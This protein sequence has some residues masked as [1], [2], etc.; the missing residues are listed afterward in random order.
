MSGYLQGIARVDLPRLYAT[1]QEPTVIEHL[2][3][4]L[5]RGVSAEVS[6]ETIR[7]DIASVAANISRSTVSSLLEVLQRLFVLESV[8]AWTPKLR[9]RARLRITAKFH[10]ADPALTSVAL[11]AGR[12]QLR[13]DLETL[14]FIFESAVMHDLSVYAEA[15]GGTLFHYRDSNGYEIDATIEL[16]NGSWGAIEIK[17]GASQIERGAQSLRAAVEQL[18][19]S[20]GNPTF[21]AVITGTGFTAPLGNGMQTFPL[22]A[23]TTKN[24]PQE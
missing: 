7:K 5:A 17:L 23:L 15:L 16:P 21:M 12:S 3:R 1:R 13:N 20:V 14:G 6:L 24:L 19:P 18:D 22:Q 4:A 10:L 11:R 9:S 2:I 8:P